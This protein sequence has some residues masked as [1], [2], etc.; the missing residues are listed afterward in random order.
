MRHLQ[1]FIPGFALFAL[2]A[3]FAAAQA[4]PF[5]FRLEQG[6]TVSNI[7]DGATITMAADSVGVLSKATITVTYTG[8]T[9]SP[10]V[11]IN[12]LDYSGFVGFTVEASSATP[13]SVASR[14]TFTLSLYYTASTSART[15]GRFTVAYTDGRVNGSFTF[16]LVGTA[17][18]FAFS[19]VPPGGNATSISSGGKIVFPTIPVGTSS[20]A[21]FTLLNRG[22]GAGNVGAITVTGDS[23]KGVGL[24]LPNTVL[25]AGKELKFTIQFTPSDIDPVSG[26]LAINL[27]GERVFFVLEGSGA[28]PIIEYETVIDSTISA[29]LPGE[30]INFADTVVGEKS[31]AVVRV[32]NV[33]NADY[34]I[35][36]I[37]TAGAAFTVTDAPFLPL[38]LPPDGV[39]S[40]TV[41]F[42]PSQSGRVTGRLRIGSDS[43][44]LAGSGVAPVLTYSYAVG[45]ITTAV[46]PNGSV[47]FT[48]TA[49]GSTAEVRFTVT[50]TGTA[51]TSLTSVSIT[52]G[53]TPSVFTATG[54]PAL[55]AT[56]APGAAVSFVVSFQP[57]TPVAYT[58]TLK[59]D[60]Q[61]F[62]LSAVGNPPPPLP[63][64]RFDG[65]SGVVEPMAQPAVGL[66]LASAYPVALS[67]TL[68]LSFNSDVAVTD[69][70]LQFATGGKTINFTIPANTTRAIFTGGLQQV[71]LQTGT[72]AGTILLTPSFVTDGGVNVTPANPPS[73]SLTI[74]QTAPRVLSVQLSAKTNTSLTLL[75]TGYATGRS[76]TSI[77]LQINPVTGEQVNTRRITI[78]AEASFLAWFTSSQSQ[79]YGSLFTVTV[80]LTFTGDVTN[81]SVLT[82]TIQS[83]TVTLA[84][85]QGN[86]APVTLN[87]K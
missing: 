7:N 22:S 83:I 10:G 70:A 85:R 16:N 63:A 65:A 47:V 14:Q 24:P 38:T 37:S 36:A 48:P 68:T 61:S 75:I 11:S 82:D 49:V 9:P 60:T 18:E 43:F 28:S 64:Y 67:G 17:P 32:R 45:N 76:V 54:L 59:L 6:A 31:S 66:T 51:P 1:S 39:A 34:R 74:P 41:T 20:T 42:A 25:D 50:N 71:R 62:T 19:Y 5:T 13:F 46:S 55:P 15:T 26:A 57:L 77:D 58:A 35:T 44:E 72:V 33:G 53:G 81:V 12:S 52:G 87:L 40:V 56:I 73:H 21:S 79:Q 8:S 4:P 3:P 80:P 30:L 69:P 84:N 27:P 29:I 23:F 86:S 78:P 2:M